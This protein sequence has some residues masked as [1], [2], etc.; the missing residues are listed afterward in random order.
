[1]GSTKNSHGWSHGVCRDPRAHCSASPGRLMNHSQSLSR[2]GMFQDKTQKYRDAASP[3]SAAK[4]VSEENKKQW[5]RPRPHVTGPGLIKQCVFCL[6]QA[7]L[8][9]S[10]CVECFP[11]MLLLWNS[12]E[13]SSVVTRKRN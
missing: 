10:A 1:M 2:D 3:N 11:V 5:G 12:R 13:K 4:K 8:S 9:H 7:F 6:S